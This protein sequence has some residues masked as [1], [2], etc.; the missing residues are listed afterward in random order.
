[1]G[2]IVYVSLCEY[3]TLSKEERYIFTGVQGYK[4][5]ARLAGCTRGHL[6]QCA[7]N[8]K[9]FRPNTRFIY[10]VL[11]QPTSADILACRAGE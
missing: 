9:S 2:K 11:R 10:K 3:D 7:N 5:A 6:M 8:Q 4:D 1:M